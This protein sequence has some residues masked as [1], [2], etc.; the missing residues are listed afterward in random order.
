MDPSPLHT[1]DE[2]G[3]ITI[4]VA[5]REF[6]IKPWTLACG[7]RVFDNMVRRRMRLEQLQVQF[8][9]L[10][11]S[12]EGT[13]AIFEKAEETAQRSGARFEDCIKSTLDKAKRGELVMEKSDPVPAPVP[14]PAREPRTEVEAINQALL[15]GSL[16]IGE[17]GLARPVPKPDGEPVQDENGLFG[18]IT[19]EE[20]W[21][22]NRLRGVEPGEEEFESCSSTVAGTG[23]P[24]A[25]LGIAP[26][27]LEEP[28]IPEG[29]LQQIAAALCEQTTT[30]LRDLTVPKGFDRG[31]S[32]VTSRHDCCIDS[33]VFH[34]KLVGYGR[35]R[36][37]HQAIGLE[38]VLSINYNRLAHRLQRAIDELIEWTR[39][40]ILADLAGISIE[41]FR[42]RKR[43]QELQ[44][45][46]NPYPPV[47][48]TG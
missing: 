7:S 29:P 17:S 26:S 19:E 36:N 44:A 22:P 13:R 32:R 15:D 14:V 30:Y 41:E 21:R 23:A 10:G 2:D 3:C 5:G 35:A 24:S 37:F 6:K 33:L 25:D 11:V 47:A 18:H 20:A 39:D 1:R 9:E 46:R 31:R 27:D 34:A 45:R 8:R 12:E 28:E 16:G 40:E 4:P 38:E 48:G 42:R 43:Q